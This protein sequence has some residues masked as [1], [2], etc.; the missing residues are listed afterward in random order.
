MCVH[1]VCAC[2]YVC[3]S[4]VALNIY[5]LTTMQGDT[6]PTGPDGTPGMDGERGGTGVPGTQVI[7][8]NSIMTV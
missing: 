1:H 7:R 3:T 5:Y 2:V 4:I 8:I 6:G